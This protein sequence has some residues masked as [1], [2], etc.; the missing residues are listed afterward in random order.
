[1]TYGATRDHGYLQPLFRVLPEDLPHLNDFAAEVFDNQMRGES[2]VPMTLGFTATLPECPDAI[3]VPLICDPP[4]G[5]GAVDEAIAELN[6]MIKENWVQPPP[7]MLQFLTKGDA[8]GLEGTDGYTFPSMVIANGVLMVLCS[9]AHSGVYNIL[10]EQLQDGIPE[11][12]LPFLKNHMK[13]VAEQNVPYL[14]ALSLD[15][16]CRGFKVFLFGLDRAEAACEVRLLVAAVS[17]FGSVMHGHFVRHFPYR[18]GLSLRR[19]P[20][21]R[22]ELSS[23]NTHFAPLRSRGGRGLG[24][25]TFWQEASVEEQGKRV[26]N[27]HLPDRLPAAT[28]DFPVVVHLQP[29]GV[30]APL[31][32]LAA[33]ARPILDEQLAAKGAV[34]LRGLPLQ[35]FE[36]AS[37]FVTSLGYTMYPDPS[38]REQ[39]APGLYHASLQVPA[40]FNVS[41]HQEHIVSKH[42]PAK[43]FLY[44]LLPSASGGETPLARAGD[45]WDLIPQDTR[46]QLRH[47]R[48]RFELERVNGKNPQGPNKYPRSWQHANNKDKKPRSWQDHFLTQDLQTAI[49]RVSENYGTPTV[50]DNG[51]I[52]VLSQPLE[53]FC[54]KESRELY[55]SQLQNIYS[56]YW[57]WGDTDEYLPLAVLEDV[58]SAVWG[59]ARVYQWKAGDVL[60]FDNETVLHG[61]LSY[62]GNRYVAAALTRD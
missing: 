22:E 4:T 2:K 12:L 50:D 42:P 1:M 16:I 61:R 32:D 36:D 26:I 30:S 40:D 3:E 11:E 49:D 51:N 59:A 5:N 34:L 19:E 35:S 44:C 56:L 20:C 28:A 15:T 57:L 54:L 58:M 8:K 60:V 46:E 25:A 14:E 37:K 39:V 53:V 55:R 13:C 24:A 18:L 21:F 6:S 10:A 38:G 7:D 23:S 48:V 9:Y 52:S 33:K 62:Q 43:L 31:G 45:V 41:P 27:L 29:P 47:R 17:L